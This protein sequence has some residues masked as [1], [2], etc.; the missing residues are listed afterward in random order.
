MKHPAKL[1]LR[2]PAIILALL[3]AGLCA[4]CTELASFDDTYVPASVGENYPIKVVE[5][6]VRLTLDT[7]RQGV[8][9]SDVS[10]LNLFAHQAAAHASTPVTISYPAGS[11]SARRAAGQAAGVL[12]KEGVP[13]RSI[14]VTPHEGGG[15]Q[16]ILIFA[17]KLAET[18]PCGD[19][20]ENMAGNQFNESGPNFGCSVQNNIAAMVSNPEDFQHQRASTPPLSTTQI[21]GLTT[22][23]K[24]PWTV[25]TIDLSISNDA[26]GGG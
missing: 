26:G 17:Q 23:S 7:N 19:W 15:N 5:R 2:Q 12:I 13:R 1:K 24:G 11:Q 20:S 6:P 8:Q 10:Q 22:Y 9:P 18:K 4:G 3:A 16:L 21:P 25:P 14:L